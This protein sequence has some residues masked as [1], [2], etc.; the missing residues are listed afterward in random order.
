MKDGTLKVAIEAG[1]IVDV[2]VN[3]GL[4]LAYERLFTTAVDEL[5]GV[6]PAV[7]VGIRL[8]VFGCFWL[9]S[10]CNETF[11]D[12]LLATVKPDIAARSLWEIVER[13]PFLAKFSA[14]SA[15]AKTPDDDRVKELFRNAKCLFDLRNRLAHFKDSDTSVTGALTHEEFAKRIGEFPDA[16]LI[17]HLRPPLV[18]TYSEL[19]LNCIKWFREVHEQYFR[20]TAFT[21]PLTPTRGTL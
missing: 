3:A 7:D 14:V 4:D 21:P 5:Q 1:E 18:N 12:L 17:A 9:E 20:T 13:S 15:F 2:S 11:R 10:V 6:E 16:E 19:V 8:I